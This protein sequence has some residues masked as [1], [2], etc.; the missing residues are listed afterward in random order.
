MKSLLVKAKIFQLFVSSIKNCT[1]RC[2]VYS[3]ALHSHKSVF[4]DIINSDSVSASELVKLFDKFNGFVF[5]SVNFRR[6]SFFKLN[7]NI[8]RFVGSF[9]GRY[10]ELENFIEIRFVCR[11]LKILTLMRQMPEV[12]VHGVVVFF[13]YRNGYSSFICIIYFVIP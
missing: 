3:A 6:N 9:F 4:Y 12:S 13:C 10:A 2:F 1:A 8:C 7:F 5:F 11:V